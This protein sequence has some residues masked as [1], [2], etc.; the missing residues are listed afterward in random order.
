MLD[1]PNAMQTLG[2]ELEGSTL[3]GAQ[4]TLRK[5]QP[6]LEQIFETQLIQQQAGS[7]EHVNPLYMSDEGQQFFE[8]ATHSLLVTSLGSTQ[9]LIRALEVKLKKERDIDAVLGFQAEPLL[10]YPVEN[11]VLDRVIFPNG[12]EGRQVTLFAARKDHVQQHVAFWNTLQLEPEVISCEPAALAF[13][14]KQFTPSSDYH[15]VVHLGN[16]HTT[17]ALVQDGELIAAQVAHT[18]LDHL[19]HAFEQERTANPQHLPEHLSAFDFTT[20]DKTKTPILADVL[21][22]WRLDITRVLYALAKQNKGQKFPEIIFT[23]EG[24]IIP[25]LGTTLCQRFDTSFLEVTP[26]PLFPLSISELQR[27]A[28][29][30]GAALSG[31]PNAKDQINFRQQEFAYPRP[32]KRFKQPMALYFALCLGV[33]I[34]FYFF[35]SA[36]HKY[37]ENQLRGHYIHFLEAMNKSYPAFEQEYA[38]KHPY[39]KDA[40]GGLLKINELSQDDITYRLQYLHK[41]LKNTPDSFP[42]LPNTPRVSEVLAWLSTHSSAIGKDPQTGVLDPLHIDSFSYT[43]VKRPEPKKPTEKYQ[44]KIELEFSSPTPK[45]A[46]EFHDALIAPN[47]MVDPKGEVKWSTNRGKYRT[48]FFLKDKTQ[49]PSNMKTEG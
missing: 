40:D 32:W 49:Y 43:M 20:V 13:F 34:A 6:A 5:G 35:G 47:D 46:R 30:I 37:Q 25:A 26:T 27:F 48:S 24:A 44:V 41:E 14:S 7:T 19:Q 22:G 17:C 2:V 21:D 4:L 33:A 18:G 1:K 29:P 28:I 31:L 15:F 39:E 8:K 23:G 42:L 45:L 3:K 11:A 16:T 36:Y 10:P 38:T 9:V 12:P